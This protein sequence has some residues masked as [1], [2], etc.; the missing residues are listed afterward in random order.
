[1]RSSSYSVMPARTLRALVVLALAAGATT[2]A[3]AAHADT[4]APALAAKPYIG[5]GEHRYSGYR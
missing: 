1:M 3:P 2:A 4:T 5:L